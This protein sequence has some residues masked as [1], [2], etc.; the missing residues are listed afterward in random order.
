MKLY[1]FA[2]LFLISGCS[3]TSSIPKGSENSGVVVIKNTSTPQLWTFQ[4]AIT[5]TIEVCAAKA[6]KILEMQG[7]SNITKSVYEEHIYFYAN[8]INNR[9]GIHCTNVGGKS[10]VYGAVAGAEVKTV[11]TLR[12]NIS[13]KF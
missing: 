1:A 13:W 7:Y 9:A 6:E 11:E 10:F 8:F 5:G 2:I 4:K 12:N 3:T